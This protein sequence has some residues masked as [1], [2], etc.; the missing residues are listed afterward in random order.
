[1]QSDPI[2]FAG[3][4]NTFA[5]VGGNPLAGFDP[6][7]LANGAVPNQMMAQQGVPASP[8]ERRAAAAAALTLLG[9]GTAAMMGP[10]VFIPFSLLMDMMA[11][12][13][14]VPG[15]GWRGGAARAAGGDLTAAERAQIQCVVNDAGRPLDVVG[16]AARGT[17]RGVGTSLPIGKGPGTRSD[18][19]YTT[20]PSSL[21]YFKGLESKLPSPGDPAI[22]PGGAN[23]SIG[24]S[25]RFEPK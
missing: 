16:S 2:G 23:P 20:P 11:A 7:G 24:P 25:I 8:G 17:R 5:Y 18:I 13:E 15:A 10:E 3:G 1:M 6:L 22:F 9:F 14:G 12:S 21:P 4:I 19:D